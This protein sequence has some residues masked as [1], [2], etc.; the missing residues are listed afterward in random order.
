MLVCVSANPA[1]DRRLRLKNIAVGKVNRALSAQP[2]PGGKAAHVAMVAKALDIDVVW[3]GFLGGAAGDECESGLSACGVPVT[4]IRTQTETRANLEIISADG[5][6]TEIL[7][8]GG[9]VT[10]GEVERLLTTCRDIFAEMNENGQVALSGS[11]PPGA[12]ADLYAELTRMAHL[13]GCR[14]LLDASGEALRHGLEAG[15]DFVKPNCDEASSFAGYLIH[16]ADGA[17]E[18]AQ[19]FFDAGARSVAISLGPGGIVWQRSPDSDPLISQLPPVQT[20]SSVG[21]GDAALAGFAVAY[22]RGLSDEET[23]SLAV[24]CGTANCLAEAPGRVNGDH[25]LRLAQQ[26]EVRRQRSECCGRTVKAQ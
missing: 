25:V 5:S 4:V 8:P 21:S 7:E 24:A 18:A 2:F 26:A 13:Y 23:L 14:V 10:E 11:L 19:K 9:M 22:E 20:G 3:A 17:A 1:I 12:P 16:D 15:P 6:V